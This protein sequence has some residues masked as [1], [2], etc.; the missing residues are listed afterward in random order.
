[1]ID[2]LH[3]SLDVVWFVAGPTLDPEGED[4][5]HPAGSE[6][7]A[8]TVRGQIQPISARERASALGRDVNVGLYRI[9][10]EP[11]AIDIVDADVVIR[12]SGSPNENLDG[13][14]RVVLVRDAAGI[15]HHL[16]LDANR[17]T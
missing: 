9:F 12:K 11:A 3:H 5:G 2:L 15:G 1:M 6:L 8:G 13:D 16:E 4:L 17:T 7:V 14:Y 10:L